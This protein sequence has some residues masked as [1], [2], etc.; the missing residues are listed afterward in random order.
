MGFGCW[1][2]SACGSTGEMNV[3]KGIDEKLIDANL[4]RPYLR[5]TLEARGR[6]QAVTGEVAGTAIPAKPSDIRLKRGV[7]LLAVLDSGIQLYRYSYLWSDQVYVGVMA[8]DVLEV[9]PDAVVRGADGFLHVDYQRLGLKLQ[10]WEEWIS[11][12]RSQAAL[13][14]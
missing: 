5:P 14:A 8:Q 10:T 6:L 13:A 2:G 11:N 9:T 1:G 12:S 7:V 3:T 4:K